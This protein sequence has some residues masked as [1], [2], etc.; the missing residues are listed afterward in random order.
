MK[1]SRASISASRCF[2]YQQLNPALLHGSDE[3]KTAEKVM[4]QIGRR[5]GDHARTSRLSP[6]DH[7]I[8]RQRHLAAEREELR[9][10]CAIGATRYTACIRFTGLHGGKLNKGQVQSWAL[11]PLLTAR[12]AW[13]AMVISRP[14][15][16]ATQSNGG[17]A[18]RTTTAIWAMKAVSSAGPLTRAWGLDSAYVNRPGIPPATLWW[19]GHVFAA[20]GRRSRR[21]LPGCGTVRAEP[22]TKA[23]LRMLKHWRFRQSRSS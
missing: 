10:R 22:G 15:D 4:W 21:C 1:A 13:D 6:N 9:R 19:S 17:T 20:T 16:R 3:R 11:N 18:S 14:R 7:V 12:S 23:H 8:D 5:N 2:A